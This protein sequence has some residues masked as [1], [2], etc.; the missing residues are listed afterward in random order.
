MSSL[1]PTRV[2]QVL[3]L[4]SLLHGRR[5]LM[6]FGPVLAILFISAVSGGDEVEAGE[7]R[8]LFASIYGPILI[9]AGFIWAAS[10]LPEN[11]TP[12]GR[13]SFLTLPASDSEKWLG[14]YL[15]SGPAF[16]LVFTI[17]YFLLST[18]VSL[19]V[20]STGMQ[21]PA[22][23]NPFGSQIDPVLTYFLVVQP[24]GFLAA[25]IFNKT[26]AA[27]TIGVLIAASFALGLI[28]VLIF[29]IVFHEYFTGVFTLDGNSLDFQGENPFASSLTD[30]GWWIAALTGVYLLTV[31][32]FRFHEKEV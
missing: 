25:I 31:A 7:V 5:I 1:N 28:G 20:G 13:Q 24:I 30:Y 27:K 19:I 2:W 18:V 21:A 22:L 29:R 6:Y 23:F 15:F 9:I 32:Y 17:G 8:N 26:A 10:S 14:V 3:R 12:D 4:Q 16:Y 11:A